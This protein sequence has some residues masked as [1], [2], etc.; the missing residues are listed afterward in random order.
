MNTN[1]NDKD[2]EELA[3][4]VEEMLLRLRHFPYSPEHKN[5]IGKLTPL[6]LN[7]LRTI[8]RLNT[9]QGSVNVKQLSLAIGVLSPAASRNLRPL[10]SRGLVV[11]K[12]QGTNTLLNLTNEGEKWVSELEHF[13]MRRFVAMLKRIREIVD[14]PDPRVLRDSVRK[15]CQA[16]EEAT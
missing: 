5:H 15:I 16:F 10:K 13:E 9:H 11:G 1:P 2:L 3:S 4:Q 7:A 6:H 12:K 8:K 14:L